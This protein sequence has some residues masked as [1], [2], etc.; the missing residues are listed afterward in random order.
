MGKV[1]RCGRSFYS[2]RVSQKHTPGPEKEV[3]KLQRY[4]GSVPL[5]LSP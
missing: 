4:F 3:A 5:D 2:P 1:E